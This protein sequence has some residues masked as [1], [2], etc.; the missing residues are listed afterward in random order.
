MPKKVKKG[1]YRLKRR[2]SKYSKDGLWRFDFTYVYFDLHTDIP[3]I[4]NIEV[5]FSEIRVDI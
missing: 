5:G 1:K 4:K 3:N 2:I